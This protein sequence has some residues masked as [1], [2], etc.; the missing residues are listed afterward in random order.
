[1]SD[2]AEGVGGAI[3][4]ALAGRAVEPRGAGR[5]RAGFD[6]EACPNC[7]SAVSSTFC[8]ECGQKLHVQRSLSAILHDL[9]H[10]VLHL[11][12]KI[13][14]TLPKLAFKPGKL[15]RRY[16]E[17]ERAKFVSPM[18]MFLFSVFAMFA[19]FQMVGLTTPADLRFDV[20]AET[21]RTNGQAHAET[22]RAEIASLDEGDPVRAERERELEIIERFL[23]TTAPANSTTLEPD[24]NMSADEGGIME[25]G[26]DTLNLDLTGIEAFDEGLLKK[27]RENPGL[28]LYKLQANG[29]KLV[30][31]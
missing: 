13:W 28:M 3:E 1:M 11:D 7:G 9:V 4:G 5:E 10:G 24:Q 27:W 21:I 20:P 18:A 19:V 23:N 29:Y 25:P 6:E 14:R 26:D 31:F 17:G 2:M 30:G 22:M 16:I 12:G 8:P 15:T